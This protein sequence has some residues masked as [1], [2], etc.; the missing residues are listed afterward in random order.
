MNVNGWIEERTK[1]NTISPTEDQIEDYLR[2]NNTTVI[3]G[4]QNQACEGVKKGKKV[5][6]GRGVS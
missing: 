5:V 6:K 3:N 4:R 1:F 2:D